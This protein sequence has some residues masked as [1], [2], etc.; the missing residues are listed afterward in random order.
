MRHRRG[1]EPVFVKCPKC[2]VLTKMDD[3]VRDGLP[4][5]CPG[6]GA[7]TKAHIY[8]QFAA[9][10]GPSVAEVLATEAEAAADAEAV[11]DG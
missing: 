2:S 1:E 11:N 5:T 8:R 3:P 9:L 4:F 6:C 7:H 10:T